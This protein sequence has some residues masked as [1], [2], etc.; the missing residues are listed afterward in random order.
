MSDQAVLTEVGGSDENPWRQAW[1][2][3]PPDI[4]VPFVVIR[5]EWKLDGDGMPMR[6]IHEIRLTG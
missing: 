2:C 4:G 1:H 6:V 5:D 3:T